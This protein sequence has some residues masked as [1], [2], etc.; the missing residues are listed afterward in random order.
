LENP[1]V[2]LLREAWPKTIFLAA[3]L[4]LGG[5]SVGHA[6][7]RVPD[8]RDMIRGSAKAPVTIVEY[9]SVG[10]PHCAAL[11]NEVFPAFKA[12][13]IDTGK[14]RW[15]SREVITGDPYLATGGFLLARCAGK[16]HYFDVI[17]AVYHDQAK[18]TDNLRDGLLGIAKSA[19]MTEE[20]F[21]AC[22]GDQKNVEA[23]DARTAMAEA[24]KVRATPTLMI[25]GKIVVDGEVSM[26]DLDKI[27]A[28]ARRDAA[29]RAANHKAAAPKTAAKAVLSPPTA[30]KSTA[31]PGL[32]AARSH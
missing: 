12:K 17:D 3:M 9:A 11:H 19:G 15:I 18:L 6:A 30:P 32:P 14:V 2:R 22:I 20:Q 31:K 13:Y 27:V 1:L 5:A 28:K 25:R 16:D 23:L 21:T 4:A 24:D 10:C 8:P 29:R 7:W 26:A